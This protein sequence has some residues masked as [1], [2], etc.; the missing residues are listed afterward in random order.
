M[1]A[2]IKKA[3]LAIIFFPALCVLGLLWLLF[4]EDDHAEARRAPS[5]ASPRR[6]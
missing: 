6:D 3:A 5:S 4:L 1:G 2:R